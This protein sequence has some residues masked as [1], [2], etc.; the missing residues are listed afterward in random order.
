MI[1][2]SLE[3]S[4]RLSP[5][6]WTIECGQPQCG[7]VLADVAWI[8]INFN[9]AM[10]SGEA[11]RSMTPFAALPPPHLRRYRLGVMF[12]FDWSWSA[13]TKTWQVEGA[14]ASRRSF[15]VSEST[16]TVRG[17]WSVA[18][19]GQLGSPPFRILCFGCGSLQTVPA[20]RRKGTP[21]VPKTLVGDHGGP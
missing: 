11:G 21:P 8:D 4:A 10:N 16:R 19:L 9:M 5:D 7:T 18:D 20:Q 13:A 14:R 2:E 12:P 6:E 3:F 15:P 17:N 1:I